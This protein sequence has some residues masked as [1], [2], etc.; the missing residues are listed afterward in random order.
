M[1]HTTAFQGWVVL[2]K[3]KSDLT[4]VDSNGCKFRGHVL[5]LCCFVGDSAW[6]GQACETCEVPVEAE[7]FCS[8]LIWLIACQS[9][10]PIDSSENRDLNANRNQSHVRSGDDS[11]LHVWSLWLQY[12]DACV[13][14]SGLLGSRAI[15]L[16]LEEWTCEVGAR[17]WGNTLCCAMFRTYFHALKRK[18]NYTYTVQISLNILNLSP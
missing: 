7:R 4:F 10:S 17:A 14:L 13:G 15:P 16:G 9:W 2:K 11:N 12:M 1:R 3:C 6:F 18:N 8:T 5:D